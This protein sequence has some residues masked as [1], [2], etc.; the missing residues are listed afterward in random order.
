MNSEMAVD[1]EDATRAPNPK[2]LIFFEIHEFCGHERSGIPENQRDRR[3][4]RE[5]EAV[6]HSDGNIKLLRGGIGCGLNDRTRSLSTGCAQSV[7]D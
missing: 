5:R 3:D 2:P 1:S 4:F 6:N 7:E